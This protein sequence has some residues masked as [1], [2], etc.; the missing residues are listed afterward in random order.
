[1]VK[2]ICCNKTPSGFNKDGSSY[3]PCSDPNWVCDKRGKCDYK[4]NSTHDLAKGLIPKI[5][6]N[7]IGNKKKVLNKIQKSNPEIYFQT[8]NFSQ[9][10][11][12]AYNLCGR[13]KTG[14]CY[15]MLWKTESNKKVLTFNEKVTL[16]RYLIRRPNSE[17]AWFISTVLKSLQSINLA[18]SMI[19]R[20]RYFPYQN[21]VFTDNGKKINRRCCNALN[22]LGYKKYPQNQNEY[23]YWVKD[24][25]ILT[26]Y[27]KYNPANIWEP[28]TRN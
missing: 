16:Y 17:L 10:L 11:K 14:C 1:M 6:Y 9:S 3:G 8:Y 27:L 5:V 22:R 15:K 7:L 26:P 19:A 28:K 13:N 2:G 12:F 4:N 25:R 20:N 21:L 18:K 23:I 24:H